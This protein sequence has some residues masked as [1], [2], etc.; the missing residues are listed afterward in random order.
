MTVTVNGADGHARRMTVST[1]GN[2]ALLSPHIA[3]N[4]TP[5]TAQHYITN[6][7]PE[8]IRAK[9]QEGGGT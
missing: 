6:I 4:K 5:I 1:S 7:L 8:Y 3:L 9:V 2:G